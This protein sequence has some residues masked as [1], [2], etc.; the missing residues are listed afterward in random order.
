[1][2]GHT[3]SSTAPDAYGARYM[4]HLHLDLPTHRQ[5]HPNQNYLLVGKLLVDF[6]AIPIH[7][8]SDFGGIL[9]GNFFTTLSG[10]L[11][12]TAFTIIPRVEFRP[13]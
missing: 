2:E 13:L 8:D 10:G 6:D 9:L 11:T 7:L 1:M 5:H 4:A 3:T 12:L